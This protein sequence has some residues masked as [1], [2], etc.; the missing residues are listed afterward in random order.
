[1]RAMICVVIPTD[2]ERTVKLGH[3][4]DAKYYLHFVYEN[5]KWRLME[6]VE[7]PFKEDEDHG[8]EHATM[9]KR[10]EI[11]N[12]NERCDV[13]V[14]TFFGPG[15]EEF[16]KKHGKKVVHVEPKTSVEEA[17]K[18]VEEYLKASS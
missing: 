1:M 14:Y 2:D 7:N 16:M 8:H 6:K 11:L 17:L 3:F 18:K 5:G 10:K 15:G 4:G 9:K 13:F 12:L